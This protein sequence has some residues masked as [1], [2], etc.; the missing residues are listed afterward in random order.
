M[1][2][3]DRAA[4][5]ALARDVRV[6]MF[7]VVGDHARWVSIIGRAAP[8]HKNLQQKLVSW[9]MDPQN[10]RWNRTHRYSAPHALSSMH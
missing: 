7:H 8:H 10:P 4:V 6:C 3:I 9:G 2:A 5:I 1:S